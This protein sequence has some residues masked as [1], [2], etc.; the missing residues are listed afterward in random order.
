MDGCDC[1]GEGCG[2]IE[3]VVEEEDGFQALLLLEAGMRSELS[4]GLSNNSFN[5]SIS[6]WWLFMAGCGFNYMGC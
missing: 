3:Q 5:A 2:Y 6:R 1:G 4:D